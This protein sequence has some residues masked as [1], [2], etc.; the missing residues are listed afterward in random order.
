VAQKPVA[1]PDKDVETVLL[2]AAVKMAEIVPP[3]DADGLTSAVQPT[4]LP[5]V[6]VP[7]AQVPPL[8]KAKF[9]EFDSDRPT[10][11]DV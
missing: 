4:P 8:S 6:V 7:L 9:V 10:A 11:E 1:V 3:D 5:R 2:A